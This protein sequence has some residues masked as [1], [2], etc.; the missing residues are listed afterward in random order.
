MP[1]FPAIPQMRNL[2][3][4]VKVAEHGSNNYRMKGIAKTL[5]KNV[6]CSFVER[7]TKTRLASDAVAV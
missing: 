4:V 6:D 3:E 5:A 2:F 1:R 7:P